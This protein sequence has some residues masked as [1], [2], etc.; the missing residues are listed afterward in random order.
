MEYHNLYTMDFSDEGV[1]SE[2]LVKR[3]LQKWYREIAKC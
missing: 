3:K 2:E 1:K